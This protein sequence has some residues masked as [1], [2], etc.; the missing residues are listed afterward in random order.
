MGEKVQAG[1]LIYTVLQAEWRTQIEGTGRTPNNRFLF[2]RATITN[3]SKAPI[4]APAFT[5]RGHDGQVYEELV[6][7]IEGVRNW[8]NI[9][10]TIAPGQTEAGYVVFDAP[11][12]AYK[13][14]MSDAGEIGSEKYAYVDIPV[15]LE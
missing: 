15:E 7:G 6:E 5:L 11:V 9:L 12:A 14:V 2:I 4:S 10:R 1:P 3:S 13:L 8:L